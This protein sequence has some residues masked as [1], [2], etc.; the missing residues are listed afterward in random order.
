MREQGEKGPGTPS[1]E[2]FRNMFQFRRA[3]AGYVGVERE[4]FILDGVSGKIVPR[5]KDVL[6]WLY[7]E[8]YTEHDFI[9]ELPA[10]VIESKTGPHLLVDVW[11][12]LMHSEVIL[13]KTSRELGV[14]FGSIEVAPPDMPLDVYPDPAG[15][16]QC[17]VA[18]LTHDELLAG[19]RVIGTHIHIGMPDH[20]TALR[21][22]NNLIPISGYLEDIGDHSDGERLRI[23]KVMAGEAYHPRAYAHWH[24]FYTH[25]QG[26][27]FVSDPR[28]C[29]SIIR[30]SQHGTI[31]FRMFGATKDIDEVEYWAQECHNLCFR[32]SMV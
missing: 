29:W 28:K 15:R 3:Y 13:A 4:F 18:G 5:S 11:S 31:E 14:V 16:Y 22:Y 12:N 30:I 19:S 10:S 24:D 23:Y 8:G 32:A 2:Q 7:G 9:Y 1:Y 20:E 6:S 17:I 25:A 21:V 26:A 27:G